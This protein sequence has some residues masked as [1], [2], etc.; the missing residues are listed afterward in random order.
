[1]VL[2]LSLDGEQEEQR[3]RARTSA[4]AEG[5]PH[6]RMMQ[7]GHASGDRNGKPEKNR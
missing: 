5:V 1:V 6:L 3:E 4:V 2:D 7:V